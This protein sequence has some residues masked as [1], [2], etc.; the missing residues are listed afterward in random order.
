MLFTRIFWKHSEKFHDS[1][2]GHVALRVNILRKHASKFNHNIHRR[3][4][5]YWMNIGIF[6]KNL[7]I[8]AKFPEFDEKYKISAKTVKFY[9]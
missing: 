7:T 2:L 8:F 3:K 9:K 5:N 4:I 1:Y 6:R